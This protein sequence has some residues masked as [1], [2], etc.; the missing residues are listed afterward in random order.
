MKGRFIFILILLVL[1]MGCSNRHPKA[2]MSVYSSFPQEHR[3]LKI[4]SKQ[5]IDNL[6]KKVDGVYLLTFHNNKTSTN[7][8]EILHDL[9]QKQNFDIYILDVTDY[10]MS[11]EETELFKEVNNSASMNKG[12]TG[13]MP[14]IY[15]VNNGFIDIVAPVSE[16]D[17]ISGRYLTNSEKEQTIIDLNQLT[18]K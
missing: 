9:S 4:D 6:D 17:L 8:V 10:I 13:V 16:G 12:I 15:V 2:D 14:L 3:F 11:E 5:L 18:S 7:Y 1:L